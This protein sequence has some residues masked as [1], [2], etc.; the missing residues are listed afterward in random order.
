[1]NKNADRDKQLQVLMDW[2]TSRLRYN[3]VPRVT[4]VVD[5]AYQTM[6]FRNLK[7]KDIGADQILL[8]ISDDMCI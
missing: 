3:D 4:D 2:V 6:G 1:M 5:Y 7:R 8:V